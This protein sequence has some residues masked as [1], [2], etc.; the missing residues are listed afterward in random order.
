M[1]TIQLQEPVY[2]G[3]PGPVFFAAGFRPFFLFAAVDAAVMLPLWLAA[4]VGGLPLGVAYTASVWHGHEM[5]F[6]FAGAAVGGFLLTAVPNWTNTH[7]VSGKPLMGLF[8]AW[9][10]GRVA[11][12]LGGLLPPLLVAA[13]DLL[14]LPLLA[15]LVGGP[16]LKAGKA[17]NIAFLPILGVFWLSNLLVHLGIA[18]GW[19][20]PMTGVYGGIAVLLVMIA[21]VG[22][23]I[24]PSFTQSWLRMQGRPVEVTPIPWVEKWGA[25]A[26]VVVAAGLAAVAPTSPAAGV[27]LLAAAAIHLARMSRWHGWRTLSNPILWILHLGYLWLV[28]G[29]ALLG[30]SSF[31]DALPPSAAVHALTAGCVATMILG[32]MSRAALGHSG[33]PLEVS[34]LTVAAYV[35]LSVGAALR[36]AAPLFVDAQVAFTHA[37]GSLWALAW[38]LF[39]VVYAPIVLRP[40]ADGRPG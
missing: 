28:V 8:A 7:H 27:A 13:V 2:R 3:D 4:W 29:L 38:L 34:P 40:R 37:G 14:Y 5:V 11:F 10:A 21:V 15:A 18:L 36:V 23:R 30:L 22:G 17:R 12:S 32:V 25:A 6:G 16:L 9:L 20:E 33:R 19:G 26:S 39:I 31:W 1:A 24:V 35:L